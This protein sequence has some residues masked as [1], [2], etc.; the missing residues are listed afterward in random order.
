MGVIR[1]LTDRG[2]EYCGRPEKHDYQLYLALNEIEHTKTKVRH[3]QTNGICERFH[4]T[5]LQEFYQVAF[6]RRIH[7]SIDELRADVAEWLRYY[8]NERTHQGKMCRGRTPMQT[9]IDGKEAWRDK[10][11][12]LNDGI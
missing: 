11:V 10:I 12:A 6:R 2:T 5:I 3:P 4:K 9:L 1:I 7:R 8:N